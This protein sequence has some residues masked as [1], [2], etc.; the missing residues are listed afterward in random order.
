MPFNL[1]N[2]VR[3][4]KDQAKGLYIPEK[5][6]SLQHKCYYVTDNLIYTDKHTNMH[7]IVNHMHKEKKNIFSSSCLQIQHQ[8]TTLRPVW[9]SFGFKCI[10]CLGYIPSCPRDRPSVRDRPRVRGRRVAR[11]R[12]PDAHRSSSR[13]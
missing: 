4:E 9:A 12:R 5:L 8:T 1:C 11:Q 10:A 13:S 2:N 6:S 7:V 3:E